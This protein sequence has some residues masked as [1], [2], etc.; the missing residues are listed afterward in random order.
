MG[1]RCDSLVPIFDLFYIIKI[2]NPNFYENYM[3]KFLPYIFFYKLQKK[4]PEWHSLKNVGL[5]LK[6]GIRFLEIKRKSINS[7]LPFF[8]LVELIKL[9]NL[10]SFLV[11]LKTKQQNAYFFDFLKKI[12]VIAYKFAKMRLSNIVATEDV[13]LAFLTLIESL[14]SINISDLI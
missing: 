4:K 1:K 10:T 14:K 11:R 9:G 12:E 6:G 3:L 13:R 2:S 8:S 7:F 5:K